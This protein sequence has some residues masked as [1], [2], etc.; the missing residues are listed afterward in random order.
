MCS[1]N[2][3]NGNIW[4]KTPFIVLIATICCML[5]GS[6]FPS[7]K[8]G[9]K[10]FN[11]SEESSCA[12]ILFAGIRFSLS[13]IMVI[14]A[15][16]IIYRRILIPKISSV[17]NIIIL[18]LFQ[19]VGQYF[20]FYQGLARTSG[21]NASVIEATNTFFTIL[22]ACI[23]FKT[24]KITF[25][26]IFGCIIGFTG[27]CFIELKGFDFKNL[28]FNF[29]GDGF[30]LLSCLLS[31]FVPSLLKKFSKSEEP[32]VLSGWQ[33]LIGG[34]IMISG[35]YMAGGR[36]QIPN[37]SPVAAFSLLSYMAFISACAYTLWTLL[38]KQNDVSRVAIFG[39]INPVFAF[40]LSAFLLNEAADA[41]N[42]TS[43]ISL[44]LV[45]LGIILVYKQKK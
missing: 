23:I 2:L 11:I 27:V 14:V 43:I 28:S 5:W 9:Y 18:S 30:I 32:F 25:N 45:S 10:L 8:I 26:K 15:G 42:V 19:T 1:N 36:I 41:F 39:F 29:F 7:I 3:K 24:E 31:A 16:S 34:F 20:F 37:D 6:A 4:T 44:L 38:L 21:V 17:I 13:G 12:Q 40:I 33:F 35:A 22:L